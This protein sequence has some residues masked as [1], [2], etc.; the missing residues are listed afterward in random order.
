MRCNDNE[1][2]DWHKCECS[3]DKSTCHYANDLC[4]N[5]DSEYVDGGCGCVEEADKDKN[6]DPCNDPAQ[7]GNRDANCKC[8]CDQ[9]KE[10]IP[11]CENKG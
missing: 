2:I 6:C 1:H 4:P 7:S 9:E 8:M 3:D 5:K 11:F 10:G